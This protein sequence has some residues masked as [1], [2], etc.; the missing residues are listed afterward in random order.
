MFKL[1]CLPL[2]ICFC[3]FLVSCALTT[4]NKKS[5][6]TSSPAVIGYF[7]NYDGYYNNNC[8]GTLTAT[9]GHAIPESSYPM[10]GITLPYPAFNN[11]VTDT[12]DQS[13]AMSNPDLVGKLEGLTVLVYSFFSIDAN[14]NIYFTDP[15]ADLNSGDA[16]FCAANPAICQNQTEPNNFNYGNF[17]A[18]NS[19]QNSSKSLKHY[20]S[21]GGWNGPEFGLYLTTPTQQTNFVNSLKA[22]IVQ[23]PNIQGVDLDIEDYMQNF[24]GF[25]EDN[26]PDVL[27]QLAE[28]NDSQGSSI[29]ISLTIQANP[30]NITNT[31]NNVLQTEI[32]TL[33]SVNL[34]TYDFH[35]AFDY[36]SGSGTT[37]FN[38]NLYVIDG[39]PIENDFSVDGAVQAIK[40]VIPNDL[41]KVTIG[42]AAYGRAAITGVP[43]TNNGLFQSY[44]NA[45][46]IILPGDMDSTDCSTVLGN[47]SA[48]SWTFQ[49]RYILQMLEN[50]FTSQEWTYTNSG[51]TYNVGSTAYA[52]KWT[53]T[54]AASING[55]QAEEVASNYPTSNINNVFI[56]Y[57]SANDAVS[58]GQYVK[59]NGLAGTIVWE[60]MGDA[61]YTDQANSLIYNFIKGYGN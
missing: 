41:N 37:G 27:E 3:L 1:K 20:I 7:A 56:S 42:L 59:E 57:T 18:F 12:I 36:N 2:F 50:G 30:D 32:G 17:D 5:Q 24:C 46:S 44:T 48:C 43:P 55:V 60:I 51:N 10:A 19:L 33:T 39:D 8:V 23:F 9:A 58:Y 61:P 49:Y 26:L 54:T 29:E 35:G 45:N 25:V 4:A 14:G 16:S 53:P 40:S 47:S 13:P 21:V 11:C 6:S 22:I 52:S 28:V 31:F 38:S 34:M 15:W